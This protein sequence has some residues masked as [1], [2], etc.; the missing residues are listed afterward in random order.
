MS[1][2]FHLSGYPFYLG[3]K[4]T[5]VFDHAGPNS[6]TTGGEQLAAKPTGFNS[7]D[8]VSPPSPALSASST[9]SVAVR[10]PTQNGNSVAYVLMQWYVVGTGAEVANGV[11]LS[12]ELVRLHAL[13]G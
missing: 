8:M 6:Y 7:F 13:G 5:S 12:G 10:Y 2:N 11:D 9:Y 4:R 1:T 3:P